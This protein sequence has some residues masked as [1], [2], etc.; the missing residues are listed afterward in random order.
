[1]RVEPSGDFMIWSGKG[2]EHG[3]GHVILEENEGVYHKK[4]E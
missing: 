4:G 2:V 3:E 1:M